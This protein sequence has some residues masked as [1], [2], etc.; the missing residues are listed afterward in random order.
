MEDIED[1]QWLT[2][3][4]LATARH[5][6][7]DSA[8]RLVRRHEQWRRQRD[9]QGCVRVLVPTEALTAD[10]R[11]DDVLEDV[12]QQDSEAVMAVV[13]GLI[14]RAERA[15]TEADRHRE[16]ADAAEARAQQTKARADQA[17]RRADGAEVDA[18]RA[19]AEAEEARQSAEALR[20][21][22]TSTQAELAQQRILTDQARQSASEQEQEAQR[23]LQ[24]AHELRQAETARKARGRLRRAWAA[25][26]GD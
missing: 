24:A 20:G 5:T 18:R 26:R 16:R 25:W 7:T 23:A 6:S 13:A 8:T 11:E 4:E 3:A 15:E 17:H 19:T 12:R 14:A 10:I 2:L 1:G 9:N 21:E 22:L